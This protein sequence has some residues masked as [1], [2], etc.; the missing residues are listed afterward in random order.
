[1]RALAENVFLQ[2]VAD[3]KLRLED[4]Y[5]SVMEA[6]VMGDQSGMRVEE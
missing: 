5:P 2:T 6:A 1:M 3:T 4:L